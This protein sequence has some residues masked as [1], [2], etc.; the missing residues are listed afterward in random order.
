MNIFWKINLYSLIAAL[1]I[2]LTSE[3]MLNFYRSARIFNI[4]L[5]TTSILGLTA[6]PLIIAIFSI[7]FYKIVHPSA[8][9]Y[10]ICILWLPY[11]LLLVYVFAQL[12]PI[13]NRGEIPPP[14]T[15]LILIA[16]LL[17]YPILL[18]IIIRVKKSAE[19][20]L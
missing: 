1:P 15:G 13:E 5:N 19:R 3:I 10:I 4:S 11:Y 17:C 14:V 6:V 8:F 18:G 2:F 7:V 20:K 9:Y 16:K 12:F